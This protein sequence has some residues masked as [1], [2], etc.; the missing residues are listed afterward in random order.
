LFTQLPG[1]RWPINFLNALDFLSL[2]SF[3]FGVFAGIFCIVQMDFY[4]SLISMTTTLAMAVAAIM[5]CS[6]YYGKRLPRNEQVDLMNHARFFAGYLLLFAFPIVSVD[7]VEAFACHEVEG[8]FYLRAD[9]TILCDTTR[10]MVMATYAGFW[11]VGYICVFPCLL[12]WKLQDYHKKLTRGKNEAKHKHYVRASDLKYGFLIRDY[13]YEP[14]SSFNPCIM[15]EWIEMMRKLMLSVVGALWST[16]STTCVS[17]AMLISVMFYGLHC[18]YYP[19]RSMSCNRLQTLCLTVLSLVY[20]VGVLL[21]TETVE[22]A[23]RDNMG[24]FMIFLMFSIF[25]VVAFLFVI[26][27][28]AIRRWAEDIHKA[29]ASISADPLYDPALQPHIIDPTQL[30][31]GKVLGQ[32]AEGVVRQGKIGT[33][34]ETMGHSSGNDVAVKVVTVTPAMWESG[35]AIG[36]ADLVLLAQKEAKVCSSLPQLGLACAYYL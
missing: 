13:K 24:W 17:T 14:S 6:H 5:G 19:F 25:M 9:Y 23:D 31:L 32:G 35:R 18:H 30:K 7:L 2:L 29:K 20:F 27:I 3:D 10:F 12:L 16:K 21:K 22:S 26:E 15:W 1:V 8:V 11:I 33:P 4:D 36:I 34:H 28:Q